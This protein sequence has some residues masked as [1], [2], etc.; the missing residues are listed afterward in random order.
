[1]VFFIKNFTDSFRHGKEE[2]I[3]FKSML[4]DTGNMHCNPIPVMLFEY[5]K[6]RSYAKG[7][8]EVLL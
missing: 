6:G 1:M 5:D 7:M 8:E 2:D 4:E 3:L